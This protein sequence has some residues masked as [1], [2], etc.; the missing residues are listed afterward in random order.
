MEEYKECGHSYIRNYSLNPSFTWVFCMS[1]IMANIL[2]KAEFVEVDATFKASIE[3]EYLVNAMCFDY[4]SL[5]CKLY[6]QFSLAAFIVSLGAVVARVRMNKLDA[7]AYSSA[8]QAIFDS[9]KT[10]CPH[11]GIGK[12]LE[13]IITD[14]S[15]AQLHGLQAALGEELANCVIK[16]CQVCFILCCLKLYYCL[17]GPLSAIC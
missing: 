15:D 11:F 8:F 12:T 5:Q 14:W 6:N 17:E 7:M 16:G 1:P 10:S 13:G 9:V 4:D 3:L 2:G